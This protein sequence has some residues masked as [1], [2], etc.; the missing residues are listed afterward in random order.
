MPGGNENAAL[1]GK[2]LAF[3]RVDIQHR[4]RKRE[5]T[6]QPL[7]KK[8]GVLAEPA[9]VLGQ[10]QDIECRHWTASP[11]SEPTPQIRDEVL[12]RNEHRV[13]GRAAVISPPLD[14]AV[15]PYDDERVPVAGVTHHPVFVRVVGP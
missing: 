15:W 6:R 9:V 7:E 3:R 5:F 10:Y 14:P 8:L 4:D 13:V 1:R 2:L 12:G 11:L